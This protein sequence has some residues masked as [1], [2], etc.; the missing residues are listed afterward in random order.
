MYGDFVWFGQVDGNWGISLLGHIDGG[1]NW[2]SVRLF[3]I[4]FDNRMMM[5]AL[6][7][8]SICK[9]LVYG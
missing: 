8:Q 9:V 1:F 7:A 3:L 6:M 4:F 2:F 5:L